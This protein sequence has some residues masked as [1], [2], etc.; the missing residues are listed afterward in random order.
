MP[1]KASLRSQPQRR[2]DRV[3]TAENPSGVLSKEDLPMSQDPS[4]TPSGNPVTDDL[5]AGEGAGATS[6]SENLPTIN[7][8]TSPGPHQPVERL[9]SLRGPR[10]LSEFHNPI[11]SDTPKRLKVQPRSAIR[12]SKEEREAT[13]RAEAERLQ[14]R[15]AANGNTGSSSSGRVDFKSRGI[16]RGT[17]GG[18]SNRWQDERYSGTGASGFL[19]GVTPAGDKRQRE[20]FSTRSRGGGRSL[21]SSGASRDHAKSDASTTVK[22]EPSG[23]RNKAREVDADGDVNM[24]GV[25]RKSARIK[26][27]K[28]ALPPKIEDSDDDL[29]EIEPTGPRINIEHINLISDEESS[30]DAL[31]GDAKGK[32]KE[33]LDT[34]RLPGSSFMRPIRITR[35][36]HVDRSIGVNTDPSSATSAELRRR[37]EARAEA[38]GSLFLPEGDDLWSEKAT[39]PKKKTRPRDVE[40]IKNERKWQGVYPDDEDIDQPVVIKEEPKE[41]DTAMLVDEEQPAGTAITQ[42]M[43][44]QNATEPPA[45]D[46]TQLR[47]ADPT[48][49][50][51]PAP[52]PR[53]LHKEKPGKP[54]AL[55][56]RKPVLQT[57]EDHQEWERFKSDVALIRDELR[58]LK[59]DD[60][61]HQPSDTK[62]DTGGDEDEANV[63]ETKHREDGI[64]DKKEGVLYLFQLPPIM[65]DVEDPRAAARTTRRKSQT[66]KPDGGEEEE[67]EQPGSPPTATTKEQ[68][69]PP[70]PPQSPKT[71]A[72]PLPK[73][74]K[75]SPLPPPDPSP[76]SSNQNQTIYALPPLTPD[77]TTFPHG[78]LGHLRLDAEGFPS[79]TWSNDFRLDVGRASDYGALQEAVLLRTEV[80]VRE[81][82]R[83]RGL[84]GKVGGGGEGKTEKEEGTGCGGEV[85]AVGQVGGGFVMVPDWGWMFGGGGGGSG[86]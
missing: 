78:T 77:P 40:F 54:K 21:A 82:K 24:G 31:A 49:T 68:P 23:G 37:A 20:S 32:G 17:L 48:I 56:R 8:T 73:P 13:E 33:K 6:T 74:I 25:Q 47:P 53:D 65:P 45:D 39:K 63:K 2:S 27:E 42:D 29:L 66:E 62:T 55:I 64:K 51:T 5:P 36:Q 76:S 61:H 12:R 28:E 22:K 50:T 85:W 71:T 70:P 81:K 69:P 58:M 52:D 43:L 79:A 41:Q 60:N 59:V 14:A 80:V 10:R 11:T 3:A 30:D 84:G 19:G 34:P 83:G 9:A 67:E 4:E 1:P 35:H 7:S 18:L 26:K 46:T 57:E 15:F 86:G 16:A 72:T 44:A 38:Q 75:P